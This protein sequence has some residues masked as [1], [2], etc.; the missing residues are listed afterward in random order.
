MGDEG[1]PLIN[2][3][4]NSVFAILIGSTLKCDS[5]IGTQTNLGL[6]DFAQLV[7]RGQ[8]NGVWVGALASALIGQAPIGPGFPQG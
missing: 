4:A 3:N 8:Q 6:S 5:T 1:A 2:R 7:D